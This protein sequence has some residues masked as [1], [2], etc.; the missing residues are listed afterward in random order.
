[1]TG[2]SPFAENKL[3]GRDVQIGT[4]I[5]RFVE[6]VGRCVAIEVDPTTAQRRKGLVQDLQN[7]YGAADMGVFASVISQGQ[8]GLGDRLVIL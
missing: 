1:M 4:A 2:D 3:I 7:A 5:L 8:F 6:P